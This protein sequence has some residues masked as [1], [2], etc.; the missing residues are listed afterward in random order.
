MVVGTRTREARR[1]KARESRRLLALAQRSSP[2]KSDTIAVSLERIDE[3]IVQGDLIG[4]WRLLNAGEL[5]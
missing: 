2:P 1:L 5:G 4:A 3:L